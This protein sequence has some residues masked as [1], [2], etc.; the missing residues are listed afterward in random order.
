[1]RAGLFGLRLKPEVFWRLTP[2]ELSVMLGHEGANA[3]GLTRAKLQELSRLY[4]DTTKPRSEDGQ[5][6]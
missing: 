4:P 1:M 3:A 6:E 2:A 5:S